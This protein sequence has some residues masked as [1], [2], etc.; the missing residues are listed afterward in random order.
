MLNFLVIHGPNLNKLGTR[1]PCVYGSLTLDEINNKIK[2]YAASL[3][4]NAATVQFNSEGEIINAIHEAE[5]KYD[6]IVINPGAYTHYS[7][8]I[9][10]AVSTIVKPVVEVHISNIHG[11]EEFRHISVIAPVCHGQI[12]GFGVD[13]YILA[14]NALHRMLNGRLEN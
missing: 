1:E 14:I 8:A 4:I 5:D 2:S 10:D 12:S 9:R 11:R 7:I 6:A 3:S 13:S